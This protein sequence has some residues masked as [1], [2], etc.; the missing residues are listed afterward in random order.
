MQTD[1]L[2]RGLVRAARLSVD[3]GEGVDRILQR[4]HHDAGEVRRL[5][6]IAGIER[7]LYLCAR[8]AL[9]RIDLLIAGIRP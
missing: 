5:L 8:S 1:G 2:V 7:T 4:D 9:Y 6:A 3:D